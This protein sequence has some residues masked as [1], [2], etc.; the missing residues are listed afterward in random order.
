ML[1]V[2]CDGRKRLAFASSLSGAIATCKA[3]AQF[4]LTA[5]R[6][7]LENDGSGRYHSG[8]DALR[9]VLSTPCDTNYVLNDGLDW[10]EI[11]AVSDGATMRVQKF[12]PDKTSIDA[13]NWDKSF[14]KN[15]LIALVLYPCRYGN[16]CEK[17][18]VSNPVRWVV[19]NPSKC[20]LPTS[21]LK[22]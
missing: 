19:R 10:G 3:N 11:C 12:I 2:G 4:N 6:E 20:N 15:T 21:S 13:P 14:V 9:D 16:G 5:D 1:L 17:V 18:L 22:P 8:K 7:A